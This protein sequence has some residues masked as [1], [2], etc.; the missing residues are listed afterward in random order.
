MT[1][2]LFKSLGLSDAWTFA[3]AFSLTHDAVVWLGTLLC[4]AI[5]NYNL[6]PQ[7]SRVPQGRVSHSPFS[8]FSP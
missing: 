6:F 4:L 1:L 7:V 3:V 2:E 8:S 5:D